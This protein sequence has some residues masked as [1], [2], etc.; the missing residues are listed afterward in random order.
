MDEDDPWMICSTSCSN[1]HNFA[2]WVAV[3][4]TQYFIDTC[5]NVHKALTAAMSVLSASNQKYPNIECQVFLEVWLERLPPPL[6]MY[7]EA[8]HE[9]DAGWI[10]VPDLEPLTQLAAS[11]DK[12]FDMGKE[13]SNAIATRISTSKL[14]HSGIGSFWFECSHRD[15]N[16]SCESAA[17][18]L[19][20]LI[21]IRGK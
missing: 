1:D 19:Q 18:T 6:H 21:D 20:D 2:P 14:K 13:F 9:Y 3:H 16:G 10:L 4:V 12:E 5:E 8:E 15:V 17:F 7:E 11:L